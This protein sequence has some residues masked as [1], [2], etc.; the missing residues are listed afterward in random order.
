[1]VHFFHLLGDQLIGCVPFDGCVVR[2]SLGQKHRVGQPALLAQPVVVPRF[3]VLD[4]VSGKELGGDTA[5]GALLGHR[6]RAVFAELGGVALFVFGPCAA[7]AVEPVDLVDCQQRLDTAQRTHLLEGDLQR[8][9]HRGD[10]DG[11][12]LGFG[13]GQL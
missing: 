13:D 5:A 8:V 9:H 3:Q 10:S 7:H 12:G 2:G 4:G 6:L 11:F 1:M